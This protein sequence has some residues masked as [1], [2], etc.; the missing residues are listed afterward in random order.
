[1]CN[2]EFDIDF[3]ILNVTIYLLPQMCNFILNNTNT[4]Y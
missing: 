3:V 1:M 2:T 4:Q